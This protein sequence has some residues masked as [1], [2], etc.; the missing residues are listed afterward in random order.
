[1]SSLI[2]ATPGILLVVV[3]PGLLVLLIARVRMTAVEAIALLPVCSIGAV[4]ILAEVCLVLGLPFGPPAFGLLVV[5]LAALLLV[6]VARKR[7]RR[8]PFVAD[9]APEPRGGA[10]LRIGFGLLGVSVLLGLSIWVPGGMSGQFNTPPNKDS[11]THGFLTER[12]IRTESVASSDVVVSD[13]RGG[14]A[15]AEY[16]PLGMHASL[17]LAARMT[18]ASDAA[19]LTAI[20]VLFAALVLPLGLFALTRMLVPELPLAAGFAAVLGQML[21]AFPYEPFAWGGLTLIVGMAMLPVLLTVLFRTVTSGWSRGAMGLSALLVFALFNVYVSVL[22]FMFFLL[23]LL[24]VERAWLERST[25]A[26]GTAARRL[27][28]VGGVALGLSLPVLVGVLGGVSERSGVTTTRVAPLGEA[29]GRVLS[30]A[31]IAQPATWLAILAAGGIAVMLWQRKLV[32]WAIGTV[33]VVALATIAETSHGTI[34]QALTL[35]WYHEAERITFNAIYFVSVFGAVALAVICDVLCRIDRRRTV[36]AL[37]GAVIAVLV[38]TWFVA[39]G[40]SVR[41]D[42]HLIQTAYRLSSL[43]GPDQIAA[44]DYLGKR[45]P[46]D[47]LVLVDGNLDGGLWMYATAGVNPMF[48]A[49]PSDTAILRRPDLRERALLRDHL[50]ALG[51]DPR[52]EPLLK[53]YGVR[54]VYFGSRTY[55]PYIP[56]WNLPELLRNPRLGQVFHRGSAYV[57]E[58]L[59]PSAPAAGPGSSR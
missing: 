20:T 18:G 10:R 19:L 35:P 24:V 6:A 22:V 5:V 51:S 57:F 29:L 11:A 26:L 42:R 14:S 45:M 44:F 41:E 12:I 31:Y 32:A 56:G 9:L 36:W 52:L 47:G 16:Y 50:S 54:Y 17:A 46:H 3:L 33:V 55:W 30:M 27:A 7:F 25:R 13:P 23:A 8:P 38:A 40:R 21:G 48:G 28:V 43:V 49:V 1:M 59:P 53:K 37:S 39:G 58:I 34:S 15:A 2:E 4:W